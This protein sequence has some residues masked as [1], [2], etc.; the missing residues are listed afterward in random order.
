MNPCQG[1]NNYFSSGFCP[2]SVFPWKMSWI[3]AERWLDQNWESDFTMWTS[4]ISAAIE[5]FSLQLGNRYFD[6]DNTFYL[7]IWNALDDKISRLATPF[8]ASQIDIF[9][10]ITCACLGTD[11]RAI[12]SIQLIQEMWERQGSISAS[13]LTK[14]HIQNFINELLESSWLFKRSDNT[15]TLGPRA[16]FELHAFLRRTPEVENV[17]EE[18]CLCKEIITVPGTVSCN[19]EE[20]AAVLHLTCLERFRSLQSHMSNNCP[21]C[22]KYLQ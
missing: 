22:N 1:S 20:C 12:S 4:S 2:K 3:I 6:E 17:I 15:I 10:A 5:P 8:S 16:K 19:D 13:R 7:A 21:R 9:K 18:C 14:T 11:S